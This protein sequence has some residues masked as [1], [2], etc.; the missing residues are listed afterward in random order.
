MKSK[1]LRDKLPSEQSMA[2]LNAKYPHINY[3]PGENLNLFDAANDMLKKMW[4]DKVKYPTIAHMEKGLNMCER[5]IR[6]M[7]KL[8]G[9]TDRKYI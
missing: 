2:I 6:R 3:I 4:T 8:N 9:L 7:A 1:K 5:N